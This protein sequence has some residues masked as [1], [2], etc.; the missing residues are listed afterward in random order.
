MLLK[1]KNHHLLKYFIFNLLLLSLMSL[2][3]LSRRKVGLRSSFE[4]CF[5]Y[6]NSNLRRMS[7]SHSHDDGMHDAYIALGCNIGDKVQSLHTAFTKLNTIGT[8]KKTAYLYRSKPMYHTNQPAFLNT[9][10]LLRTSLSPE[11][12]LHELKKIEKEIGRQETFRNGPRAID[13]D[14]ILYDNERVQL[15]NLE[16]PHPR[17]SER[18]FV[19]KPLHDLAPHLTHPISQKTIQE[20]YQ[21]LPLT[22]LEEIDQVIPCRNRLTKNSR[23]LV[24]NSGLPLIMGILNVTPDR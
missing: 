19:L 10:C 21:Q 16:I 12:L 15:E 20:L 11:E 1:N 3:F 2:A 7:T 6:Y 4:K 5:S 18:A 23:Y 9:A 13:L 24:L 8:V 14:I 22:A 17:M